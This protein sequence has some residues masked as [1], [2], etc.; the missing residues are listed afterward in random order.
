VLGLI[1]NDERSQTSREIARVPECCGRSACEICSGCFLACSRYQPEQISHFFAVFSMLVCTY[2]GLLRASHIFPEPPGSE[3]LLERKEQVNLGFCYTRHCATPSRS[4]DDC[5]IH[6]NAA[7]NFFSGQDSPQNHKSFSIRLLEWL[8]DSG[9][10]ISQ[11]SL[12]LL[13]TY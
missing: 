2:P 13:S 11:P 5:A 10:R 9:A 12:A 1:G 6:E 3:T 7:E 4:D 8:C